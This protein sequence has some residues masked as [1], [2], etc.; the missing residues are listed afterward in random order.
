M[1]TIFKIILVVIVSTV[2]YNYFKINQS[3][4]LKDTN[5]F[6]EFGKSTSEAFGNIKKVYPTIRD[7]KQLEDFKNGY[8]NPTDSI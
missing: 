7:S 4:K 3:G 8:S 2:S 1:K 6:E 5:H